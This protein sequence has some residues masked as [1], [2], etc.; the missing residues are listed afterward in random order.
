M[1][2][3][4][5]LMTPHDVDAAAK[6][7]LKVGN[8]SFNKRQELFHD[9][10]AL[11]MA[12]DSYRRAARKWDVANNTIKEA[13]N[14]TLDDLCCLQEESSR[15]AQPAEILA[16]GEHGYGHWSESMLESHEIFTKAWQSVRFAR[17]MHRWICQGAWLRV[18]DV[19]PCDLLVIKLVL[20]E[21]CSCEVKLLE[22]LRKI[23][24]VRQ[25]LKF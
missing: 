7:R 21:A 11:R 3:R 20:Q 5:A 8:V 24:I 13:A 18:P 12:V 17:L 10:P 9:K 2:D 15:D 22:V 14:S 23:Q 1:H 6:L 19:L 16:V 25:P 4:V